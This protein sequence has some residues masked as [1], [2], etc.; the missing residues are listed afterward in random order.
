MIGK[1]AVVYGATGGL[2][3]ALCRELINRGVNIYL[4]ARSGAKLRKLADEFKLKP[5]QILN[6]KTITTNGDYLKTL[7]WLKSRKIS[8]NYAI[9]TAGKGVMKPAA[10]LDLDEWK[11]VIDINLASAF[12]FY[13]LCW[14]VRDK[15]ELEIVYFSSASLNQVW[16]KNGLYGASKAGLEAFAQSLHQ[17]IR[18]RGGRVWLY[19]LGS[20]DT[21]FFD[22]VP[23]HLPRQ[24][25][26]APDEVAGMVV[27][28]LK[29]SKNA[30]FPLIPIIPT[31][32]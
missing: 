4:V 10:R 2:G 27:E 19:R 15:L 31:S 6:I 9:H 1:N 23:H 7:N 24:K 22:N 30:Y 32:G 25:M 18:S 13:K 16:P 11:E 21:A 29:T 26:I 12:S 8:F 14:E 28:N 5:Y 17:E 3:R 20:V